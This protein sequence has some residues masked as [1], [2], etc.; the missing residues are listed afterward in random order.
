MDLGFVD[1]REGMPRLT[2]LVSLRSIEVLTGCI[3]GQSLR[4]FRLIG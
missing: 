1:M 3:E 4:I 2:D